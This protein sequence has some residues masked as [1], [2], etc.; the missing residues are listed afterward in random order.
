MASCWVE[1][2][3]T[4]DAKQRY[5][6]KFTLG[7]RAAR[8]RYA[9]SFKTAREAQLRR[10]WI[11]GELAALRVP[12]LTILAEPTI[13]PTFAEVATRWQA[14]RVDVAEATIVQHRTALN[15][16]LPVIG[17]RR[18]DTLL[19]QDV[20]DLIAGLQG[21]GKARESIRKTKTALAMVFDYA[22][23]TPNPARDGVVKL[24]REEPEEPNPPTADQL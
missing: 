24:P 12:D 9:G 7:G 10:Q 17:A 2:R 1:R 20:A 16:A 8:K 11:S 4:A 19:P 23:I 3:P 5:V 15:R 18:I 6:V 14:S 21:D 22:G 13:A